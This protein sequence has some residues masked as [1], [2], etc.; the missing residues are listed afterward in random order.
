MFQIF[1]PPNCLLFSLLYFLLP[2]LTSSSR[3]LISSPLLA[4][5]LKKVECELLKKTMELTLTLIQT[6]ISIANPSFSTFRDL[7]NSNFWP[8][9]LK[10]GIPLPPPPPHYSEVMIYIN[11]WYHGNIRRLNLISISS[12]LPQLISSCPDPSR[13]STFPSHT[14]ARSRHWESRQCSAS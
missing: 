2:S 6:L 1:L 12:D 14:N 4:W 13:Q 3:P 9:M 8:F 11:T 7:I 10:D 5:P